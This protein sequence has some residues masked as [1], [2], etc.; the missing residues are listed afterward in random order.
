MNTNKN[1]YTDI[2]TFVKHNNK[3]H[4]IDLYQSYHTLR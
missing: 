4:L 3:T 2:N 1:K